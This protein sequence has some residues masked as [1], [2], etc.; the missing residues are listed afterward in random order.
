MKNIIL[1]TAFLCLG[2]WIGCSPNCP[3]DADLSKMST[4]E[5]WACLRKGMSKGRVFR[6]IGAPQSSRV[7]KIHT[8]YTFNCFL[9]TA[10]FDTLKQ[11]ETWHEPK[12]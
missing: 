10:T 2:L 3:S 8:V 12:N 11:L 5:K 4:I 7:S 6:I 1:L 9:C